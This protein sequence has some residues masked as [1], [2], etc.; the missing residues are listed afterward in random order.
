MG[1]TFFRQRNGTAVNVNCAV[2]HIQRACRYVYIFT[3]YLVLDGHI[4][5]V[6]MQAAAR[7]VDV[8]IVTPAIPD[9]KITYR[10][11]A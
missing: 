10:L 3:P 2:F 9:K 11:T 1:S 8:R 6:L 4:R 7:E 5:A